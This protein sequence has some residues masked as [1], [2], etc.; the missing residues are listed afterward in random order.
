M[1]E[2]Y[3]S[4]KY[5]GKALNARTTSGLR[6]AGFGMP[7]KLLQPGSQEELPQEAMIR[8]QAP[9]LDTVIAFNIPFIPGLSFFIIISS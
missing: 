1:E 5:V 9:C 2:G 6:S 4:S 3:N 7:L 8:F